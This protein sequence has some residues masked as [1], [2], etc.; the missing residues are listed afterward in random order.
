MSTQY[1]IKFNKFKNSPSEDGYVELRPACRG[2]YV[3][4]ISVRSHENENNENN[5]IL[6]TKFI[7]KN[8]AEIDFID[9]NRECNITFKDEYSK[10]IYY[11]YTIMFDAS[12][13]SAYSDFKSKLN[14][15]INTKYESEYYPNGRLMYVGE[16]LY[17]QDN[18]DDVETVMVS[19]RVPNGEG[20]LYYNKYPH[21]KKYSGEFEEGEYDGAGTFYCTNGN[22]TIQANNISN[23]IPNQK[24]TL[25][26]NFTEKKETFTINFWELWDEFELKTKAQQKHFVMS[27]SF[28]SK[29]T[30]YYWKNPSLNLDELIFKEKQ[31][32]VQRVEL[33][34]EIKSLR[35]QLEENNIK[36]IKLQL[37]HTNLIIKMITFTTSIN[38]IL[39]IINIYS[40]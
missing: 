8:F 27:D 23:G 31:A 26:I 16:V 19:T 30:N 25:N 18:E 33:W 37:T 6:F 7:T 2:T 28:V 1:I 5:T 17:N 24:G 14:N 12:S 35:S 4:T 40:H 9:K 3:S 32:K 21:T 22:I 11:D 13:N 36:N 20:T 29:V 38:I 15:L 34:K 39:H 10:N